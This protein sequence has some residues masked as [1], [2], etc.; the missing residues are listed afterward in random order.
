M[1]PTALALTGGLALDL[2]IGELP[3]ASHP[4]AWLGRVIAPLDREWARPRLVGGVVALALPLAVATG[5]ATAVW[6]VGQA[7][8]A[9]AVVLGALV[10]F[11]TTSVRRLLET[12]RRV[13]HRAET[14][15][16]GAR[17][18]LL[19]LAGRD[20]D[21]L[22]AGE[23]RSAALESL[24]ENFVDGL[25][26]PLFW[27]VAGTLL[28]S[29][30]GG[31][32]ELILA[33]ATGGAAWLKA[34]NTLDSMLGYPGKPWGTGSAR[35]DDAAMWVPAR[36][37]AGVLA[38]AL[39]RP[40]AVLAARRWTPR[41]SSPNSGWPMGVLAAGLDVRL[42][43]RGYYELNPRAALPDGSAVDSA[44][45]RVGLAAVLTYLLAGLAVLAA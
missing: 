4:V 20:A 29:L 45:W 13:G 38:L 34:V 17:E 39:G 26:A 9:L 19:A 22:S 24:A 16:E 10:V 15:L 2:A 33:C 11:V 36:L 23:V 8:P 28:A 6:L 32:P 18:D 41:V 43:K 44:V 42:E 31:P 35:L 30:F 21:A 7:T 14:D 1:T 40:G 37:G 5:V 27:F 12:V 3:N 25:V